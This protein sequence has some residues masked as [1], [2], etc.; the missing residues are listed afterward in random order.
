MH[1]R[2]DEGAVATWNRS[3]SLL[4]ASGVGAGDTTLTVAMRLATGRDQAAIDELAAV[5][6]G[7]VQSIEPAGVPPEIDN[8][9]RIRRLPLAV[10]GFLLVLG[11]AAVGYGL[12]SSVRR[13]RREI[14]VWRALG[15]T[16]GNTRMAVLA[17]AT[18]IA[19]VGTVVGVPLGIV[20]GRLSWKAISDR[21]PLAFVS[22]LAVGSAR[23]RDRRSVRPRQ[24]AR[25]PARPPGSTAPPGGR[26]EG[27]VARWRPASCRSS[28]GVGLRR[29]LGS[30]LLVSV[31]VALGFG[32]AIG[33]GSIADITDR[34]YPDYVR[35]AHVNQLVVNPSVSTP[36]IEEAI[37]A[38]DGVE[39]VH[40]DDLFFA[41]FAAHRSRPR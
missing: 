10:A 27:R 11:V 2:F 18:T 13:R 30:H 6:T 5:L 19:L 24:R 4:D 12:A 14:A 21:I 26:A 20:L 15:M 8:L 3:V 29:R 16:A 33:A 34:V 23:R 38:F 39:A 41:S 7:S 37:R 17:E 31:V 25:D 1:S 35:D 32:A 22:P 36:E 40:S 9:D 28:R